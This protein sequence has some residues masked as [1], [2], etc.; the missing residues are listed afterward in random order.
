MQL[1]KYGE[2][3]IIHYKQN[4]QHL[5]GWEQITVPYQMK[6]YRPSQAALSTTSSFQFLQNGDIYKHC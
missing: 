5:M 1:F 3:G 2:G 6:L 4:G